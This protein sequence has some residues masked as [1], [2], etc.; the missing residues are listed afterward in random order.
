MPD[1]KSNPFWHPWPVSIPR[2]T[3]DT[4]ELKSYRKTKT[5]GLVCTQLDRPPK[6]Q[7]RIVDE[8]CSFFAK[9]SPLRKL[10]IDTRIPIRLFESACQQKELTAF[11]FKWGPIKNLSPLA[12]LTKLERLEIGSCSAESLS[13]LEKLPTIK[14]LKLSNLDRLDD[15][16][17]L[18]K[19]KSLVRLSIEGAPMMPK[20]VNMKNI[21][22]LQE[23]QELEAL[24]I[25]S[26]RL[27]NGSWHESF[28]S[29]PKLKY[30]NLPRMKKAQSQQIIDR[31]P[32]LKEMRL[33]WN[34]G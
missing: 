22:Y 12:N 5:L 23:L 9:P 27:I 16:S 15:Y 4:V 26:T 10:S 25:G 18:A 6:E 19:L 32:S 29:L 28:P 24:S 3:S 14:H 30:L 13:V 34:A 8:W 7:K 33:V 1:D 2:S 20:K 11:S 17:S 31:L 21:E